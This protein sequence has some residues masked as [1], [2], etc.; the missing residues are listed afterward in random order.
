VK[1][2][3]KKSSLAFLSPG[4]LPQK[5]IEIREKFGYLR[6]NHKYLDKE[7]EAIDSNVTSENDC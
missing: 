1:P 4:A 2:I 5:K 7:I 6:K 3:N